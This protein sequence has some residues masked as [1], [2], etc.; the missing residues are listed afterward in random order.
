MDLV[1]LKK[2]GLTRAQFEQLADIPPEQ[3]LPEGRQG[4]P[5]A[6]GQQSP[7]SGPAFENP[8]DVDSSV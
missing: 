2:H 3:G 5:T 7:Q 8:S 6:S 1:P 4:G